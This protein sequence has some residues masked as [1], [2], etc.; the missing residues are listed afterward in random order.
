VTE[1]NHKFEPL[2]DSTEAAEL[3]KINRYTLQRMARLGQVPAVKV[4]KLWRYQKSALD[5]WVQSKVSF[6]R[7]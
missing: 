1:D 2:I 5:E 3:L 6:F 7:H 4:G